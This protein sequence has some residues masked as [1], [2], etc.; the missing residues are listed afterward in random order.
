LAKKPTVNSEQSRYYIEYFQQGGSIKVTAIDPVTG[1]ETSIVGSAK[2]T[3][4]ELNRV[5]VRKLQYVIEK[6]A[7]GEFGK[8]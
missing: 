1:I 3:Q 4:S 2:A 6:H 5:A 8:R 7:K